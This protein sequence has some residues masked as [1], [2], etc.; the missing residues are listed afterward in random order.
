M[1]MRTVYVMNT[2]YVVL[3]MVT[4]DQHD[5][6]DSGGLKWER[7]GS[8]HSFP[9]NTITESGRILL[10]YSHQQTTGKQLKG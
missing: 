3:F 7:D 10:G 4:M 6:Q 2:V 8:Q 5:S 1:A 9:R